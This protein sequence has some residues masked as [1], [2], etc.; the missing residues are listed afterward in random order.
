M[1]SSPPVLRIS[2]MALSLYLLYGLSFGGGGLET[3]R[4]DGKLPSH[5]L[6][7]HKAS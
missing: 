6:I 7:E 4:L 2:K 5:P 3:D 1:A